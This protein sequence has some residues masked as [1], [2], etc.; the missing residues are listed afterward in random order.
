MGIHTG[1]KPYACEFCEKQFYQ[2]FALKIHRR[3]HTGER[4]YGCNICE[5][6]YGDS[7]Y[8][9]KHMKNHH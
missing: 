6:R 8:L 4:P 2:S 3:I 9:K 5:K 7:R 1:E